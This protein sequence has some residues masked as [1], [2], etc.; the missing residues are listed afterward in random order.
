MKKVLSAITVLFVLTLTAGNLLAQTT[1]RISGKVIDQKTS[2]TL[3][4]ATVNIEGTTKAAATDVDGHYVLSG[5]APGKYVVLVRY[6]GYQNKTISDVE[7]KQGA[8]TPLDITVGQAESKAL[9][10][11]TIKATYRQQSIGALYAMQKNSVSISDG[12]SAEVIKKSPDRN[13]A[14]VLKRVSGATVQDNKF[15]VIRGLSDRYNN[16]MLDGASLPSTEPNRKAFSFDIVP[17]NLVESLNITKTATPDQP[18]D[19]AGGLIQI[20]TK[21]LPE[22]NSI[23]FGIGAGYNTASTGKTFLSGQRNATDYFGFDNGKKQLP[24]GFVPY[25]SIVNGLNLTQN[26][27]LLKSISQDYNIYK[28]TALPTQNY[29]FTLSRVKDYE[30][31]GNRFGAIL[32]LTYRNSQT[33]A[34]DVKR[35]AYGYDYNDDIYKFSTNIGA[36]LNL[37]YSYG[38][39]KITFKNVYNRIYDDQFLQR[40][41]S[42]QATGSDVKYY[43]FDLLQKA[44]FKSTLE[45]N[46]PLGEKGAK[47][48][49]NLSYSNVLNDQ[50]Q[51]RK[52]SYSRNIGSGDPFEANVSTLGKD[53]ATLYAKLNENQYS[54]S[55]NYSMPFKMFSQPATFKTGLT[56]LYRNRSY[57]VRFLGAVVTDDPNLNDPDFI[58]PLKQRPV[59]TLFRSDVLNADIYKLDEIDGSDD[60]Y[61]AHSLT[62]SGYLML[63]N[64][65]TDK[66]RLVWGARVEQF[67]VN[68]TPVSKRADGIVKQNYVDILPSANLTYS[69]TDKI[70]LRASYSRTLA[71]PEFRELSISQYYDYE[72]LALQ[73]GDPNLKRSNIDNVDVR[74]ELYPSA[75][76]IISVSGFYKRFKNAIETYNND[77]NSTRTITYFN[78][79]RANV[80]GAEFEIRKTLDFLYNTNF[81]KNTTAYANVAVIKSTAYN[82]TDAGINFKY[83]KRTL[84]GQA[85][86]VI[87]AGLQH[88]FLDNKLNFNALYNRVGRR[89]N[90]AAGALYEDIWEAPRNVFDAQLGLKVFK[91]KGEIKVTAADILNNASTFYYDN[92]FNKKVDAGDGIQSSYKPGSTYSVAFTYTL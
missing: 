74:F 75:G 24:S 61:A 44:L 60:S 58:R 6:I 72:L 23:S 29:Q 47:I 63:D 32:G 8:N 59:N 91:G 22:Q 49:W 33:I 40:T 92:N 5:L 51:Q 43:A 48:N 16:A 64:K 81:M 87:N 68:V 10:E 19:F 3:I 14:D 36:L 2:E 78:S 88:S 79:D 38:K 66:L 20:N 90:V 73:Q 35:D 70:N 77:V 50:P 85:P 27:A 71:R 37:G 80:I 76:Q 54:G 39:N 1:G 28:N 45:G 46:H 82:P 55:V 21:D 26:R 52:V 42:N 84:V 34:N 7:V 4:G 65:L 62:N 18:G 31:T 69:L 67:D 30:K 41:G 89:L 56:S 13:T 57:N 86:Y 83:T 17:S 9:N 25:S 15:V 12:T 53:N 11:V